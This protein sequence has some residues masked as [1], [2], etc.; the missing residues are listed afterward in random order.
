MKNRTT[1]DWTNRI[2]Y[3]SKEETQIL[4]TANPVDS[5]DKQTDMNVDLLR[6][7]DTTEVE[8]IVLLDKSLLLGISEGKDMLDS[9]RELAGSFGLTRDSHR[10]NNFMP[11]T[12]GNR[13][14]NIL[15]SMFDVNFDNGLEEKARQGQ[16]GSRSNAAEEI[17]N[18]INGVNTARETYENA[19][20]AFNGDTD[21]M[22]DLTVDMVQAT[23]PWY[24]D[25]IIE[26]IGGAIKGEDNWLTD[27]VDWF[28][29]TTGLY[30]ENPDDITGGGSRNDLLLSGDHLLKRKIL[31]GLNPR[32]NPSEDDYD[33][34]YGIVFVED[35]TTF[36]SGSN[37]GRSTGKFNEDSGAIIATGQFIDK[38]L[39]SHGGTSTGDSE[40]I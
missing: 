16:S 37:F 40:N 7:V 21:A 8:H 31:Q 22:V 19:Q 4:Q 29:D 6:N 5:E 18:T 11:K 33:N 24:I 36:L 25:P 12:G 23:T 30:H 14:Q 3:L 10:M 38:I 39:S 28:G 27:I 13:P 26:A 15:E 35:P 32:I 17:F 1:R 34:N 9:A 2:N 20:K